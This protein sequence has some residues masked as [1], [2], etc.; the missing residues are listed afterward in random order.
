MNRKY[1]GL[2]GTYIPGEVQYNPELS[3]GEGVLFGIILNLDKEEGCWATN[4]YFGKRLK[5]ITPQSVSRMLSKLQK[6]GYIKMG[7]IS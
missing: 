4:E 1:G 6:L 2:P 3:W 5:G 7:L